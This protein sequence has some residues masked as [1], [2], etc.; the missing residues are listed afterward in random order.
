[1]KGINGIRFLADPDRMDL[2][3]KS[4]WEERGFNC[5]PTTLTLRCF[6]GS[7]L[8]PYDLQPINGSPLSHEN[9]VDSL[10]ILGR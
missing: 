3:R 9:H 2:R 8:Q 5:R 1:M 10:H 7:A 6:G 4:K